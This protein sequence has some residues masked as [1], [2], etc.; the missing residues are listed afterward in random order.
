MGIVRVLPDMEDWLDTEAESWSLISDRDYVGLV[1]RWRDGFLPLIAAAAPS[2]QGNLAMQAI[3]ERLPAD[4]WLVGGVR[5][6]DLQ[7]TGGRGA[8]TI[9]SPCCEMCDARRQ[10]RWS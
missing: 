3:A 1:R 9:K 4:V 10:T 6:P 2:W 5:V 8:A 7:N